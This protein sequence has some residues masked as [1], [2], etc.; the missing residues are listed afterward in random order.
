[1]PSR[2]FPIQ[3]LFAIILTLTT[4]TFSQDCPGLS[5]L[6]QSNSN[7][8]TTTLHTLACSS[9]L[10]FQFLSTHNSYHQSTK[11]S[12]PIYSYT[13]FSIRQQL[14]H[15]ILGL[16]FDIYPNS[17]NSNS[18]TFP[19]QHIETFDDGTSCANL[20]ECLNEVINSKNDGFPLWIKLELK[21]P[22]G[23]DKQMANKLQ[24]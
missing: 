7:S 10:Q 3:F 22:I 2:Q 13:H 21:R 17:N 16:E 18:S 9:P 20:L 19:V 15:G 12:L 8:S 1:M 4:T 24:K 6:P 11:D 23:W 5:L 14:K